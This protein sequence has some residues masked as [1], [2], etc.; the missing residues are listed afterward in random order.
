MQSVPRLGCLSTCLEFD[1]WISVRVAARQLEHHFRERAMFRLAATVLG[2]VFLGLLFGTACKSD[3]PNQTS[4]IQHM[5]DASERESIR[6]VLDKLDDLERRVKETQSL[7]SSDK[8]PPC[9]GTSVCPLES[10]R[11]RGSRCGS[12]TCEQAHDQEWPC[13]GGPSC[14]HEPVRHVETH[15]YRHIYVHRHIYRHVYWLPA[16][17]APPPWG[18]CGC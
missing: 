16:Y 3:P 5:I 10:G 9:V 8:E 6:S 18:D 15:V 7:T 17:Y 11:D 1:H 2:S 14:R 12:S 13:P 4:V